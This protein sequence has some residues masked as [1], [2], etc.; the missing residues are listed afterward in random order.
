MKNSLKYAA[1]H[2]S[3]TLPHS[4]EKRFRFTWTINDYALCNSLWM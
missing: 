3:I 2:V 1:Y 4:V